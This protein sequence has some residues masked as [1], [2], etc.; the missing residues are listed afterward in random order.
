MSAL[1]QA[2]ARWQDRH[3]RLCECYEGR[4]PDR[5]RLVDELLGD[6]VA[7]DE[8]QA[9][10]RGHPC[11]VQDFTFEPDP[12]DAESGR[13]AYSVCLHGAVLGTVSIVA[14]GGEISPVGWQATIAAPLHYDPDEMPFVG[15]QP[16]SA[17]LL[18]WLRLVIAAETIERAQAHAAELCLTRL[19]H[20]AEL[21]GAGWENFA[22][23]AEPADV[24]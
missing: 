7:L 23:D 8:A 4:G 17:V 13:I 11:A 22:I 12:Q 19:R 6:L 21:G 16:Q 10:E 9:L 18:E 15:P 24:F 1:A 2:A 5:W 20:C 14:T 3:A